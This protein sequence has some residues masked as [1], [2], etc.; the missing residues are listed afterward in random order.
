MA[1]HVEK[2][3]AAEVT[4]PT[5]STFLAAMLLE[6]GQFDDALAATEDGLVLTPFDETLLVL[7]DSEQR[8][9]R[10]STGELGL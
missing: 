7:R 2:A 5:S 9:A 4:S 1:E 10:S 8:F 6:A 3:R